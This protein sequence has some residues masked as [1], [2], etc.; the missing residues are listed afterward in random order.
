MN[1]NL[2]QIEN[3]KVRGGWILLKS[4]EKQTEKKNTKKVKKRIEV[5]K[6]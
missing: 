1:I 5:R 2:E 3:S 4:T 6:D